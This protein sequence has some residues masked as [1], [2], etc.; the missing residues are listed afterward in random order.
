MVEKSKP[1]AAAEKQE[2]LS[3]RPGRIQLPHCF[4]TKQ[5]ASLS[6]YESLMIN[7]LYYT[8]CGVILISCFVEVSIVCFKYF[9]NSVLPIFRFYK[10]AVEQQT[11][12]T[13]LKDCTTRFL[14]LIVRFRRTEPVISS[15]KFQFY[16]KGFS[17]MSALPQKS[18]EV[19]TLQGI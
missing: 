9:M 13:I 12:K 8:V 2:S 19:K 4:M 14:D 1:F 16:K 10:R 11:A 5:L 18:S 15:V 7:V 17:G 6:S 3:K